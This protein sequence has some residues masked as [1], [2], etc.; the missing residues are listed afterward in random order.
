[1][2]VTSI[3]N[4]MVEAMAE[5]IDRLNGELFCKD[6]EISKLKDENESLK[7]AVENLKKALVGEETDNA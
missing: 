1:M 7:L 3:V 4:I 6:Y 5:K 2:K